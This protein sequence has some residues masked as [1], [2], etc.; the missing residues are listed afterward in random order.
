MS[1]VASPGQTASM[2]RKSVM[3]SRGLLAIGKEIGDKA[4]EDSHHAGT[5]GDAARVYRSLVAAQS[6]VTRQRGDAAGG[7][8]IRASTRTGDLRCLLVLENPHRKNEIAL[9]TEAR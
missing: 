8:S 5:V 2:L 6:E 4:G 7:R 9:A 1:N 3:P